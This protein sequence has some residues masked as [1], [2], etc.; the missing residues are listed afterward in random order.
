MKRALW[1]LPI[2]ALCLWFVPKVRAWVVFSGDMGSPTWSDWYV[3]GS[4][5]VYSGSYSGITGT[6][7]MLYKDSTLVV[8]YVTTPDSPPYGSIG[9][10]VNTSGSSV[11]SHVDLM[12]DTTA[13]SAVSSSS[14]GISAYTNHVDLQWTAATDNDAVHHYEIL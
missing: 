10:G 5:T 8:D 11:V 6:G 7:S 3:G 9:F 2:L 13:P 1:L 14:I 12:G 4:P